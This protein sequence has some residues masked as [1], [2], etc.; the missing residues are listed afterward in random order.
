[1][2]SADQRRPG[3]PFTATN[4]DVTSFPDVVR[5]LV[6]ALREVIRDRFDSLAA[7]H[8]A[9][10]RA[11]GRYALSKQEVSRQLRNGARFPN[12]PSDALVLQIIELCAARRRN[13]LLEL[14]ARARASTRRPGAAG[15]T[16]PRQQASPTDHPGRVHAGTG[17]AARPARRASS[18][19]LRQV[20]RIAPPVLE[21]RAAELAALTEFCLQE[22]GEPYLWWQ[23]GP[24]AGKSALLATFVLDPPPQLTGRVWLLSFFV[25]ARLAGQDTRDA[26]VSELTE[27]LCAFLGQ[28]LPTGAEASEA[29]LLD[30]LA[31]AATSCQQMGGRL[32]LIVDGLDEDR[33]VVVGP[34]AHSIAGLLPGKPPAGMRVVVAG[35][36]NPPIPD[37][38]PGW[39]PLHNSGVIRRL[40]DSPYADHLQRAGR[41][42]LKRL[43]AGN[44][45]EQDVLGL[46]TA[47]RG[48]LSG[49]DLRELTDA[50]L[51]A[52]EEV[53]HTVTG[54]TFTR[55]AATWDPDGRPSV[56]LL[57]HEELHHI[58]SH[59]L[60]D[61]TLAR[62][63]DRLC[64]WADTY[65]V[66]ADGATPW[67]RRTPEY[68]IVGYPRLL[69]T[70]NDLDRL[71]TLVTDPARHARMLELSGSDAAAVTEIRN[72]LRLHLTHTGPDL[73]ALARLAYH[74][75]ELQGR[76][77]HLPALLPAVWV[78]LNQ[79]RRAE[80]LADSIDNTDKRTQALT[81]MVGALA[82]TGQ[83]DWAARTAHRI[84]D[85]AQR[86]R[87]LTDVVRALACEGHCEHAEQVARTIDHPNGRVEAL[88]LVARALIRD[89]DGGHAQRL[90]S[91]AEQ[92]ARTMD[93]PN[94]QVAALVLVA[95]VPV[96][97]GESGRAAR[98]VGEAEQ[99]ARTIDH[100][101]GRVEAL[102][103]VARALILNGAGGRA[104]Q[105]FDD[106]EQVART[107]GH[108]LRQITGLAAVAKA[109]AE[110]GHVDRAE[111]LARTIDNSYWQPYA[112]AAVAKALV[113]LGRAD[114]AEQLAR[115]SE[116][117]YWQVQ[118][119]IGVASALVVSGDVEWAQRVTD[120][121][122]DAGGHAIAQIAVAR[123]VARTGDDHRAERLV[124][125]ID[126]PNKRVRG[127]IDVAQASG[128]AH[129]ERAG[130]LM[131]AA[132]DVARTIDYPDR[133]VEALAALSQGLADVDHDWSE[134]IA[135]ET[136]R[137]A[138]TINGAYRRAG[139]SVAMARML[140]Q[141][142]QDGRA[143]LLIHAVDEPWHAVDAPTAVARALVD[144]G[145]SERAE[146]FAR[147][148]GDSYLRALTLLAIAE[149]LVRVGHR[150]R[151][152]QVIDE[153]EQAARAIYEPVE[154]DDTL[155]SVTRAMAE[156]GRLA[157]AERVA[158]SLDHV[159]HD[160]ALSVVA[161]A[162][163]ETGDH[164]RAERFART[165]QHS[166]TRAHALIDVAQVLVKAGD[167]DRAESLV[168]N[169]K[170]IA[171]TFDHPTVYAETTI[172]IA[173]TLAE[174]G[175]GAA[176]ERL[177]R[178]LDDP[179]D[180]ASGL[181]AVARV[182]A[183]IGHDEWAD[184]LFAD[185]E[186]VT[187][188]ID[189]PDTRAETLASVS[190]ALAET[191]RTDGAERL[192]HSIA[193]PFQQAAALTDLVR[194]LARVGH[195]E[196]AEQLA[197][198]IQRPHL[199][200]T[201][202]TEL[203]CLVGPADAGRLLGKALTEGPLTA[204]LPT[205]AKLRP[206]LATSIAVYIFDHEQRKIDD[207]ES[208]QN[209][210]SGDP[211]AM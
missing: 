100:P 207:R 183:R 146:Q 90:V 159:D 77:S 143:E 22:H 195:H 192:A 151:A 137:L 128:G 59:Y 110:S 140:A 178:A 6:L 121:I 154:R 32:V 198:S 25:T 19:Y 104:E 203:A 35:R 189:D 163:A 112:L 105:L 184:R 172:A 78:R 126:D 24:W 147:R 89:G 67:P 96:R 152:D 205:L 62:F 201:A 108:S 39:H 155:V 133:R 202:L 188:T 76:N 40:A 91:D 177:V 169:A 174:A 209:V 11:V 204:V 157:Q 116:D 114:R 29:E 111:Q 98:L 66:P 122:R 20:E 7:F 85:S 28:E 45:L 115:A 211:W 106:A 129:P 175:N 144:G 55:R 186:Q 65:R 56:Y 136:E 179:N 99:V 199:L 82:E 156:G 93:D 81:G 145:H 180:R 4:R 107:A 17:T 41:S 102:I 46:L 103:L 197:C 14:H 88:I 49:T 153:A 60:G 97:D 123:E 135:I 150:E 210:G 83:S 86:G 95:R 12:G 84:S 130:Q 54:R 33:S 68:L 3:R 53:L 167:R 208:P 18:A 206:Q 138:R 1:V 80:T 176:A 72:C 191:G 10:E 52:V 193:D 142:G 92:V 194:S 38:V 8:S 74:R 158:R 164:D 171:H 187:R 31:D 71:T 43:L 125:T 21:G 37:D 50:D 134:R 51:V 190:R 69:A 148:I 73:Y 57:G 185:S 149:E 141:V 58:A 173:R 48:G 9:Y 200:A 119:Q 47:A 168:A 165:I 124:G 87:A 44:R 30:R 120:S 117:P 181:I 94:R 127:L 79:I 26:F 2:R 162:V 139:L 61:D 34:H 63:R 13:E 166:F 36:P 70:S 42:E 170:Q 182:A 132:E 23:A 109:L 5:P 160:R 27:Q 16:A 101:N 15:R 196:R 118:M 64:A 113:G 161:R 131:V 75:D